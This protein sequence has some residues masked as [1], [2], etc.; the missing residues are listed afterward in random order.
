MLPR[1]SRRLRRL[2]LNNLALSNTRE[3]DSRRLRFFWGSAFAAPTLRKSA[4][5]GAPSSSIYFPSSWIYFTRFL[6]ILIEFL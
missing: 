3:S 2:S 4:K 6:K 1:C 5:D